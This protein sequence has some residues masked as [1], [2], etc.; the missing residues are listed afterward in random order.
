MKI[1]ISLSKCIKYFHIETNFIK[2]ERQALDV[3]EAVLEGD[4]DEDEYQGDEDE[5]EDDED[6]IG[7][8][9]IGAIRI[10]ALGLKP[11]QAQAYLLLGNFRP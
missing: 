8:D 10:A 5:H 3:F 9:E 11:P 7:V 6:E 2:A 4:E 1:Y